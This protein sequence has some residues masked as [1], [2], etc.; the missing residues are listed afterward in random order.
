MRVAGR[1]ASSPG[2]RYGFASA[3]QIA[4]SSLLAGG[5]VPAQR[6]CVLLE[7]DLAAGEEVGVDRAAEAGVAVRAERARIAE[8][9]VDRA[10]GLADVE[11]GLGQGVVAG[12]A[13]ERVRAAAAGQRVVA[14]AGG[15][16]VG[17]IVADEVVAC[18]IAGAA[19][20]LGARGDP[21]VLARRAVVG[22]VVCRA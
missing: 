13:E 10:V 5:R 11:A 19:D 22:L 12:A 17:G 21:V 2:S 18:G 16:R 15:E 8:Q 3:T 6:H 1:G 9:L 14:R 20:V 7:R 4:Y